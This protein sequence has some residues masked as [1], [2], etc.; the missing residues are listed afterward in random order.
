MGTTSCI[1]VSTALQQALAFRLFLFLCSCHKKKIAEVDD[2]IQDENGGVFVK[3]EDGHLT[4]QLLESPAIL[5]VIGKAPQPTSDKLE[6]AVLDQW[7]DYAAHGFTTVTELGYMRN[8]PFD[9]LL[10]DISLRES[11]PVRLA[12]YRL[13]QG[14]DDEAAASRKTRTVCCP[15]LMPE[16]SDKVGYY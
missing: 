6:T 15:R 11:C 8:Q 9:S 13:V 7:K 14:P 4:G 2:S 1:I 12:L 5:G 16:L 10:E 3:D